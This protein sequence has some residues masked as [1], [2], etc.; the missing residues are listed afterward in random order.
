MQDANGQPIAGRDVTF[1]VLAGPNS[2]K[3]AVITTDGSGQAAFSYVGDGGAGTDEIQA[4]FVDASG[5]QQ[6][7]NVAIRMW[8]AVVANPIAVCQSVTRSVGD[9]CSVDVMPAEVGGGSSDPDGDPLA[10]AIS[11][12]GPFALGATPVV[13]TATDPSGLSATCSATVTA[14]RHH[15]AARRRAQ[16]PRRPHVHRRQARRWRSPCL[17]PTTA[18]P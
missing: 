14:D 9:T 6:T 16:P 18:A 7:S 13:M 17:R 3:T 2:G 11:P 12:A 15:R 5:K 1:T 8:T 4:T 10:L